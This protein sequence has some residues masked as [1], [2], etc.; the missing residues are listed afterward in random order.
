MGGVG[1]QGGHGGELLVH[2]EADVAEVEAGLGHGGLLGEGGRGTA[3][4]GAAQVR[5]AR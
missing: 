3:G 5:S 4:G 1:L 2:H